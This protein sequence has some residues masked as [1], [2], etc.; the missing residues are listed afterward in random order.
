MFVSLFKEKGII[1]ANTSDRF[2][3]LTPNRLTEEPVKLYERKLD[4]G[5]GNE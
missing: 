2:D 4:R 5:L 3:L 1:K